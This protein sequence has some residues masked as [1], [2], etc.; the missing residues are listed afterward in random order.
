MKAPLLRGA[1][2]AAPLTGSEAAHG[3]HEHVALVLQLPLAAPETELWAALHLPGLDARQLTQLAQRLQCFTPQVSLEPPD[4]L[5][6]EVRGSLHLFSGVA[7]LRAALLQT[8]GQLGLEALLAFAPTPLAALVLARAGQSAQVMERAQLVGQLAGL[9]LAAL[10]WPPEVV[11][12]LKRT[13]VRTIGAAL[14]LPRA[15]F[16][17]RF[18]TVQLAMLDR[19]TGRSREVRAAF[20]PREVFRRR[21]ELGCEVESHAHLL[22]ALAPLLEELEEFLK[23]RQCGLM[24]LECRLRHRQAETTRCVLR[25]AAPGA[26]ARYLGALLAE[27]LNRL[28]LPEAVR[29]LELRGGT[30]LPLTPATARLW[31]PG[32]H[33]GGAGSEAHAL[34][35]RL[36]ARL[37]EGAIH[38]LR[39]LESH[40]PEGCWAIA[41]PPCTA[42]PIRQT[43]PP[44]PL[45]RPLWL[46]PTPQPLVVR[47]GLP[48][49][50]GGLRLLSEP[51]RIET[52]WWEGEDIA[53]DYYT[54]LDIHGVR[55]W[56]FRERTDPHGWFL[57]GVFG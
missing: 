53:R 32:E 28:A 23:L 13:G 51:E 9:T 29:A 27:E 50:H 41:P 40:R 35:E 3:K 11:E 16:A 5:L 33:G 34:I 4:G 18:G 12:R 57:H 15:G 48:W 1:G 45:R 42:R 25:L 2:T 37:G 21:R 55:L 26:D 44:V 52:G 24:A 20:R 8:C 38:G 56:I 6:L 39:L 36:R 19:L 22:A 30:L 46:L 47:A 7:G 10:R 54:A 14:R 49:R 31:Q 43:A 17:R